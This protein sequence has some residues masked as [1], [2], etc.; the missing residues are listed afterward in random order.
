MYKVELTRQAEK[1]FDR[2][3][4]S[5]PQLAKRVG[6]AIDC[7]AKDP[8]LGIPLRGEL[9]GLHKYRVGMF[10]IVYTVQRSKLLVTVIDIGHRKDV[11]R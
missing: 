4:K 8:E 6:Y 3:M 2:L 7:L 5:Q 9:K 1:A 10:R 11:Y